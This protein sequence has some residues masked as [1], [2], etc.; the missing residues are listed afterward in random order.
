[1]LQVKVVV[2]FGSASA[3][4]RKYL[5]TAL[6]Y[7]YLEY[8]ILSYLIKQTNGHTL[9]VFNRCAHFEWLGHNLFLQTMNCFCKVMV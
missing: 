2:K 1:M 7:N 5:S 4:P 9:S 3:P 8:W 6:Y